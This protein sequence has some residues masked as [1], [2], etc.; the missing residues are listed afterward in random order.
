[1]DR[2]RTT[3]ASPQHRPTPGLVLVT[4]DDEDL[5]VAVELMLASA[6]FEV[7]TAANGKEALRL[8]EARMPSVILLDMKMPVMNGWEFSSEFRARF[9]SRAKV[10]V[11]T[12]AEHAPVR[13]R[14]I[15]ADAWLAKPF[16]LHQL[17]ETVKT[18][19]AAQV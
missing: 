7:V 4:E 3:S 6:G 1:M 5:L 2:A 19:A 17:I 12:A 8:V 9:D 14:E 16:G 13:A 10:V 18:Q 11:M 15:G